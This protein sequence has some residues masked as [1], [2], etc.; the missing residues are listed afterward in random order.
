MFFLLL[1]TSS[2][3]RF[4][5]WLKE[6]PESFN[7]FVSGLSTCKGIPDEL[8]LELKE[9][10]GY[11]YIGGRTKWADDG[12][13]FVSTALIV[14]NSNFCS[15]GNCL[16]HFFEGSPQQNTCKYVFTTYAYKGLGFTGSLFMSNDPK[17]KPGCAVYFN[18]SCF[19]GKE[20]PWYWRYLH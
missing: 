19:T 18:G 15:W 8:V 13:G 10:R 9:S 14:Q 5:N 7:K 4:S 12:D 20:F 6:P 2:N 3:Y 11:I 1:S 17:Y 16:T